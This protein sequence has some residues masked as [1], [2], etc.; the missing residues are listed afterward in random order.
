MEV[1]NAATGEQLSQFGPDSMRVRRIAFSSDGQYAIT[2][3]DSGDI[4]WEAA[5]GRSITTFHGSKHPEIEELFFGPGGHSVL[6]GGGDT[7]VTLWDPT[8][9]HALNSFGDLPNQIFAL[10]M[11]PDG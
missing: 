8:T 9:G 4:L 10:T 6:I 7:N 2:A 3:T 5:S 1:W 11:S